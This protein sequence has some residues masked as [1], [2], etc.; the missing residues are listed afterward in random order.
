[1]PKAWNLYSPVCH[2]GCC[3]GFADDNSSDTLLQSSN[4]DE[5]QEEICVFAF[6]SMKNILFFFKLPSDR[7]SWSLT[8]NRTHVSCNL[9]PNMLFHANGG[10][11]K[12][13]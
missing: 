7:V 13:L 2:C 1:L 12:K 4:A 11:F 6:T 3:C 5:A 9:L 8:M 10:R